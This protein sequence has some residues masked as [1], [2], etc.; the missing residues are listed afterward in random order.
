M[1]SLVPVW[2]KVTVGGVNLNEVYP[3]IGKDDDPN[4]FASVHKDVVNSAYE[5]IRLKGCTSWA[6]GLCCASLCSAIMRNKN[7]VF[8]ITT[9][10][11]VGPFLKSQ[12]LW[13]LD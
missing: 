6:I 3:K 2:S 10:L 12:P 13:F 9:S 4:D 7:I 11:K 1:L 5:I 8:P